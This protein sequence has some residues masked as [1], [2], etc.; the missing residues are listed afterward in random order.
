MA[1]DRIVNDYFNW[2]VDTVCDYRRHNKNSYRKL[3]SLLHTTEFTY[4]IP[5]D[6]N[7]EKDGIDL[8]YKFA[9]STH[10]GNVADQLE[11]PCT[12][13]EMLVALAIRWEI[14]FMDD[15]VEGDRT[16]V[17][18]WDMLH[19]LNLDVF[20]NDNFNRGVI[21]QK[22]EIFLNRRYG[23]SGEGNIF[24]LRRDNRDIRDVEIWYQ[25]CWYINENWKV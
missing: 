2:L 8:R 12:V 13:L 19:N 24:T 10:R 1:D 9:Y 4:L 17:W 5:K 6:I 23:R 18:F 11:G 15:P 21:L 7:R 14:D 20:T 16:S 25:L 22:I 3:L